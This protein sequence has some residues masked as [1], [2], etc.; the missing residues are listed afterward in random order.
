VLWYVVIE[1]LVLHNPEGREI[2]INPAEITSLRETAPDDTPGKDLAPGIR[3]VV[4]LTDGKYA[5]VVETCQSIR[6]SI[7]SEIDRLQR[8]EK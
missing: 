3:C 6:K 5:S 4:G 8:E 7:T 1:L 2:D